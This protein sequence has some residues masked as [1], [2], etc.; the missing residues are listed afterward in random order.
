MRNSR[1][2]L[3]FII[4]TIAQILLC[5]CLHLSQLLSLWFL[6]M[7]IL[8]VPIRYSTSSLLLTAFVSGLLVDI[9]THGVLGLT[10]AALLP[11]ALL[12]NATISIVFG[13]EV[14]SRGED[15]S[16]SRQGFPKMALA[17]MLLTALFLTVYVIADGAGTRPGWFN[18]LRIL[19]SL[20]L[21]TSVSMVLLNLLS[22]ENS[23]RWK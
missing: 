9:L 16:I 23:Q 14:F 6:P 21:D 12:R 20:I 11:V 18:F 15:I 3:T 10:S 2:W 7:M 4:L 19:L 1:F 22:P 17:V 5:E 8:C 13:S